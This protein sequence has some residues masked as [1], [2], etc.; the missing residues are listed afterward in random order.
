MAW[1]CS[2]RANRLSASDFCLAA[3]GDEVDPACACF[4]C[5][6]KHRDF[7]T[8]PLAEPPRAVELNPGDWAPAGPECAGQ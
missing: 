7:C 1:P 6:A 2:S 3:T 5:Q 8:P 4:A